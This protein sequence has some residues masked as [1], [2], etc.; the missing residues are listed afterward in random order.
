MDEQNLQNT[1]SGAAPQPQTGAFAVPGAPSSMPVEPVSM[2]ADPLSAGATPSVAPSEPTSPLASVAPVSSPVLPVSADVSASSP[3]MPLSANPLNTGMGAPAPT[4]AVPV[5]PTNPVP[6]QIPVSMM[7]QRE[8]MPPVVENEPS[9]VENPAEMTVP[10]MENP[11]EKGINKKKWILVGVLSI[12]VL[13]LGFGII[14]MLTSGGDDEVP[15]PSNKLG[16]EESAPPSV[17]SP[18]ENEESTSE[19]SA[20][21]VIE[22]TLSGEDVPADVIEAP[23]LSEVVES[24]EES[25][26]PALNLIEEAGESTFSNE[27]INEDAPV[28]RVTR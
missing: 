27:E 19:L 4:Q 13:A 24:L 8:V 10:P 6:S 9:Q 5:N 22:D 26:P 25:A 17:T 20:S 1:D 2:G 21:E 3:N 14:F 23:E 15:T 16:S 7:A 28:K 11:Q 18:F 12:L